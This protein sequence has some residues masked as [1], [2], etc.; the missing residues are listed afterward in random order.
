M[1]NLEHEKKLFNQGYRL[2]AGIDEAG[3]GPLAGPVVAACVILV[4]KFQIPNSKFQ[5]I[6]DSK[7]LTPKKRQELFDVIMAEFKYVGI[8]KRPAA[9][10]HEQ[11]GCQK[12]ASEHQQYPSLYGSSTNAD[13]SSH[14]L[15]DN[16]LLRACNPMYR[17][18]ELANAILAITMRLVIRNHGARFSK[19]L[20]GR[21]ALFVCTQTSPQ[22]APPW[23]EYKDQR[24]DGGFDKHDG[25]S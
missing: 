22:Y 12:K 8:G 24:K 15:Y 20:L 2:I 21:G 18:V 1:L 9:C 11:Q 3:R 19:H 17:S 25:W 23:C 10:S 4:P 13:L 14:R 6:R 5:N 7:K 16:R